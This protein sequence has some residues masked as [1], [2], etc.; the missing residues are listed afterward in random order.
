[1]RSYHALTETDLAVHYL[2]AV[3]G[4][5]RMPDNAQALVEDVKAYLRKSG[6]D[7]RLDD[8]VKIA[9]EAHEIAQ[10]I[11][12][13]PVPQLPT[14]EQVAWEQNLAQGTT[15]DDA[16]LQRADELAL[17]Q[18]VNQMSAQEFAANRERFGLA[19]STADLLLGRE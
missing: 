18:R 9:I 12:A 16:A 14:P 3:G 4:A 19:T 11:K 10:Q 17:A 1:M 15:A 7:H 13:Q 8:A 6:L 2:Q 5:E